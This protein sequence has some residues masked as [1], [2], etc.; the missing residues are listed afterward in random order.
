MKLKQGTTE[1]QTLKD[2]MLY[3]AKNEVPTNY[4]V[5]GVVL[6]DVNKT[7]AAEIAKYTSDYY[8]LQDNKNLIYRLIGETFDI[9]VPKRVLPYFENFAT[10]KVVKANDRKYFKIIKGKLRAK[11][12]VTAVGLS[13]RYETFRLDT[14]EF[15]VKT[16]AIG[17]ACRVNFERWANGD[18]SLSDYTEVLMDGIID[19]MHGEVQKALQTAIKATNRPSAN[20][21][22]GTG[23]SA[24]NMLKLCNVA[25]SYGDSAVIYATPEF[26]AAMG[27]DEVVKDV[28][29]QKQVDDYVATG[30]IKSFRG[31]PIV[32][33]PQSFIDE[34]NAVTVV[35]PQFAYIFPIGKTKPVASVIEGK[36]IVKEFQGHDSSTEVEAYLRFGVSVLTNHDWCIYQNT[37]I[38]D[39]SK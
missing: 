1:Y 6:E 32:E 17:G 11:Q 27:L 30:K 20:K 31:F 29:S 26:I 4:T 13:G 15:E 28:Y 33:I 23:F 22:S 19:R 38:T 16:T 9:A 7:L 10:T 25:K 24:D 21:I 39:T 18:E 36:T 2:L 3:S 5:E 37:T 34:N 8:D 35:N 14:D 12:F